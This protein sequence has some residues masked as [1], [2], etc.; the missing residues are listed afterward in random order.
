MNKIEVLGI[1]SPF[2]DDQLGWHVI[3]QLKQFPSLTP[4]IPQQLTLNDYDRPGL[5]LLERIKNSD[6]VFLVDAIKSESPIASLHRF[7]N[8]AIETVNSSLSSHNIGLASVIHMGRILNLLPP[9]LILY[10]IEIGETSSSSKLS[11]PVLKAIDELTT[12]IEQEIL[13]LLS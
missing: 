10:G 6:T 12:Q 3:E 9:H 8:Q 11:P 4:F 7:E 5:S 2:G 1:G 13:S